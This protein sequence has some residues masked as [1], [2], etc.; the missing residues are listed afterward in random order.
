MSIRTSPASPV[1]GTSP[2]MSPRL[3][4]SGAPTAPIAIRRPD[5]ESGFS[6]LMPVRLED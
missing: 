1:V 5:D 3:N 4:G 6:M 2:V